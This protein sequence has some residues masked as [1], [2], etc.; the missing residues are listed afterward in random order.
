MGPQTRHAEF[1]QRLSRYAIR[2]TLIGTS[3]AALGLILLFA[4]MH[5]TSIAPFVL[6]LFGLST[7]LVVP[8]LGVVALTVR[9][10][11]KTTGVVGRAMLVCV[12]VAAL[13]FS[14]LIAFML[15]GFAR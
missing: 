1:A 4:E 9:S 3:T 15:S 14:L 11:T 10:A 5:P 2:V 12:G 13:L 8:M 7:L 6:L